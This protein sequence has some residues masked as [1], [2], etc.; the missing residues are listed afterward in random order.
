M[1]LYLFGNG[2][3]G[4]EVLTWISMEKGVLFQQLMGFVVEDHFYKDM[5]FMGYK[6]FSL[7]EVRERGESA[8]FIVCIGDGVIRKR[9]FSNLE[10]SG[11]QVCSYISVNALISPDCRLGKGVIVNPQSRISPNVEIGDGTILNCNCGVGHD[12]RIGSFVTMLGNVAINGDVVVGNEA[13]IGCGVVVHPR[14]SIGD[15]AKLGIGSVIVRNVPA[16]KTVF[17]NP[18]K[19]L[20]L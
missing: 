13:T 3:L 10:D 12:S 18:A 1:S 5:T 2:G 7:S 6:T 16:G 17:G 4:K 9:V 19:I 14:V 15:G 20:N 8:K 11:F